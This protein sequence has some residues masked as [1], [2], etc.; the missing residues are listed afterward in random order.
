MIRQ[1]QKSTL[2]SSS[3]ASDVYKRQFLGEGHRLTAASHRVN[4]DHQPAQKDCQIETP[5]QHRGEDYRRGVDRNSS[6]QP[7][8]QEEQ[9]RAQQTGFAIETTAE[10]FVSGVNVQ[11]PV[12]RQEH[13]RDEDQRQGQAE[14]ILDETKPVLKTLAGSRDKGDGARLSRHD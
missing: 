12:H 2:S 9:R 8:L 3:A 6:S 13:R 5:A 7:P 1:P 10:K 11:T 4:N 14:V